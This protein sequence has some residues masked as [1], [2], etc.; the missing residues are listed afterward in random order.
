MGWRYLLSNKSK[1]LFKGTGSPRTFFD[2][3]VRFTGGTKSVSLGKVLPESWSYIRI[4][5]VDRDSDAVTVKFTKL[6][7]EFAGAQSTTANQGSE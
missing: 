2:R 3:R 1:R 4:E 7:E 5:I 6:L